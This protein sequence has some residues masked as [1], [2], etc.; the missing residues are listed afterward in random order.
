M[1]CADRIRIELV[2]SWQEEPI[3]ELYRAGG[4][5][6]ED[7][8]PSRLP[9]LISGSYL[10][11][12]AVDISTGRSIGM[13]RVISDGIADAYIQDVVV[14]PQWRKKGVGK[15]VISALV[16]GCNSRGI[17]WIGVIAQPGSEKLYRALGFMPMEGHVPMLLQRR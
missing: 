16:E 4:W 15:M 8:D 5:W 1:D 9:E 12:V 7:M 10:F 17:S 6:R 14:L 11:A 3:V 2:K 13:G